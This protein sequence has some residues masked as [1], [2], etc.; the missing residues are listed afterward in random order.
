MKKFNVLFLLISFG[1]FAQTGI[2][3]NTPN[4]SAKL[5]VAAT[6]K[7]FLPPRVALTA[8]NV[9]SP[10]TGTSSAA[11]GLLVYNTATAGTAPNNVVPG[12]YYWNGTSWIQISGGLVIESKTGSF[13]LGAADNNKLFFINSASAVTVTVP[14]LAI[15][16][17]CQLIQTGAGTITLAGS[18]TTLNSAS[19]LSTR[20]TNSVIGLVMNSTTVGYVFGDT[21]Y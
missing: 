21:I 11:T 3:T 6:D 18:G 8:S 14:S 9:F 4:A 20:T 7:G 17:T 12:Y 15:G 1:T 2:G 10:I 19:G 16:F 13:T 5:E